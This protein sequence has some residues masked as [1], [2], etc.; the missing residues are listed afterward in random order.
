MGRG[1]RKRPAR[2]PGKLRRIRTGLLMSQD[3]IIVRM[4]LQGEFE[5]TEISAFERGK[6]EPP[7]PTLLSYARLA[8]VYMD[9][10]VD[11]E[12][13]LPDK[14]P[15]HPKSAGIPRKPDSKRRT[16][17]TTSKKDS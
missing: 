3:E 7:L 15:A 4:G 1:S 12:L 5:R 8:G 13:D 2:L 10:L 6:R 9:A 14:L 16:S 11:D 17:K